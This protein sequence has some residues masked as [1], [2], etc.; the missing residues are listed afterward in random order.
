VGRGKAPVARCLI[1]DVQVLGTAA[2]SG[3]ERRSIETTTWVGV[4]APAGTPKAVLDRLYQLIGE[5]VIAKMK[6]LGMNV[7]LQVPEDFDAFP[8]LGNTLDAEA[9]FTKAIAI[10]R[11]QGARAIELKARQNLRQLT[12]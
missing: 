12:N 5:E 2:R 1:G 10:A 7:A 4:F 9:S 6:N 8:S 11:Q 3:A